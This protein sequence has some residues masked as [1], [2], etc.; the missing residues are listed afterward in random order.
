MKPEKK[1]TQKNKAT[2]KSAKAV[3]EIKAKVLKRPIGMYR[4]T[5]APLYWY[6]A[7]GTDIST[8]ADPFFGPKGKKK[9]KHDPSYQMV[10]PGLIFTHDSR[11][12]CVP[13]QKDR[14]GLQHHLVSPVETPSY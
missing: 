6:N 1:E 3:K 10:Y 4:F 9:R 12:S 2:A 8:T 13:G 5:G 14:C 11:S 7:D